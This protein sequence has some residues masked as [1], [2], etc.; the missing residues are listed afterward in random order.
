M[1]EVER[2]ERAL[3][4]MLP[5]ADVPSRVILAVQSNDFNRSRGGGVAFIR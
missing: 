5:L 3:R 2:F 1:S 4:I